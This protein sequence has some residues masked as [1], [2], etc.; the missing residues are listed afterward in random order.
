M[1]LGLKYPDQNDL[2]MIKQ[3]FL[4]QEF[5]MRVEELESCIQFYHR[6]EAVTQDN[7]SLIDSLD[8][9]NLRQVIRQ[10]MLTWKSIHKKS[11]RSSNSNTSN[12][13]KDQYVIEALALICQAVYLKKGY[14]PFN[15]QMLVVI[16]L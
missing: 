15:I 1:I 13:A 3:R 8:E 7:N 5:P 9:M 16:A 4:S 10:H 12:E 11:N 14:H 2:E 6:I